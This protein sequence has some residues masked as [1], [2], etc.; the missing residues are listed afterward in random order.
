M[1]TN[2]S[3]PGSRSREV[4]M[5]AWPR[6]TSMSRRSP[7]HCEDRVLLGAEQL[8]GPVAGRVAGGFDGELDALRLVGEAELA[9]LR[10]G[11]GRDGGGAEDDV[12]TLVR[13]AEAAAQ[14]GR[15]GRGS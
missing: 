2:M 8:R 1:K 6:S 5:G 9:V 12:A 11:L 4:M 3:S 7:T 14:A 13:R 15:R 10:P